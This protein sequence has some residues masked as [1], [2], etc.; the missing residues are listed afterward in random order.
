[1]AERQGAG[2]W[3]ST[4]RPIR[5]PRTAKSR[6]S[7]V[8]G[9]RSQ[10]GV[11]E[12]KSLQILTVTP[13]S[14]RLAIF[15]LSLPHPPPQRRVNEWVKMAFSEGAFEWWPCT[16]GWRRCTNSSGTRPRHPAPSRKLWDHFPARG[17][18]QQWRG[19]GGAIKEPPRVGPFATR[20]A[21]GPLRARHGP[22]G[23]RVAG[24]GL[25]A[26]GATAPATNLP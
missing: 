25:A 1:V 17:E 20:E 21:C 18:A 26:R 10:G 15:A 23:P 2:L 22:A 8:T 13:H 24:G 9:K 19:R 4:S 6:P 16:R 11:K 14:A 3:M 12:S 7:I 5:C